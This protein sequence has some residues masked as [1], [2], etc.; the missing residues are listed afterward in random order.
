M[1]T[2]TKLQIGTARQRGTAFVLVLAITSLLVMLG[3]TTT[4]LSRNEMQRNNLDQD[5]ASVRLIALTGQDILHKRLDGST[6]WR[7]TAA[8]GSWTYY[9]AI[10]GVA[11]YYAFVDQIDGDVTND[12][13]QPFLLY[14]LAVDGDSIRSYIVELVPDDSGNLTRNASSFRQAI[15]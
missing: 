7:A 14:T 15:F 4:Q 2:Q 13:T 8:N 3:I 11:L 6:A 12:A 9:G 5:Q 10:D 1:A